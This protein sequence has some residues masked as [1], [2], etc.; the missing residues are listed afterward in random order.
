MAS[1]DALVIDPRFS[2]THCQKTARQLACLTF[3]SSPTLS[4]KLGQQ[5]LDLM[6]LRSK[7]LEFLPDELKRRPL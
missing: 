6:L 5:L 7:R 2:T 4:S 3:D 1:H